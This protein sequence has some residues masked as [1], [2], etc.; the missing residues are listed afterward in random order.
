MAGKNLLEIFYKYHP[1]AS[2]AAWLRQAT[3]IALRAD[4]ENRMIEVRASFPELI[5]KAVLYRVEA[6]IA[7]AYELSLVRIL[8][9]Y[10]ATFFGE[11][12]IGE[13]LEETQ[14]IGIV[15]RGFFHS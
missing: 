6:E 11:T 13:L 1:E 7:R 10:P 8:P 3:D 14:R 9:R 12:Y 4:K 15:A 2:D 5:R